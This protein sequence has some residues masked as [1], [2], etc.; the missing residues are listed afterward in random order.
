M[1]A[2]YFQGQDSMLPSSS[3]APRRARN[4]STTTHPT[5]QPETSSA[6]SHNTLRRYGLE[7]AYRAHGVAEVSSG[8]RSDRVVVAGE[9][10]RHRRLRHHSQLPV[11]LHASHA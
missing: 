7:Q 10:V 8:Q 1:L 2:T 4:H 5:R 9:P 3:C 6:N 11:V